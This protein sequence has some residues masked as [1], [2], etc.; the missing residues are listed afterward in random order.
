VAQSNFQQRFSL[1]VW[2]RILGKYLRGLHVIELLSDF[3][4]TFGTGVLYKIECS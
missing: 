4:Q 1:N 2:Y 3:E